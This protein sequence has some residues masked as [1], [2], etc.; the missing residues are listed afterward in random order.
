MHNDAGSVDDYLASLPEDRRLAI[1]AVRKVIRKNLPT[2]IIESMNWGMIAYEIPLSVVPDTYNGQPHTFA[3]LASQ[4]N[5]MSVYLTAIYGSNDLLAQFEDDY[6]VSGKRLDMG[7]SCVRFTK[8]D[9][10]PLEVI[11]RAIASCSIEQYIAACEHS[12]TL[13]KSKTKRVAT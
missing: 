3:A 2:G 6:R 10:L 1:S 13:R 4:K 11:G 7:K 5:Y 12:L 8:L 9:D